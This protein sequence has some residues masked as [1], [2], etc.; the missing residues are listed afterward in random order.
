[1]ALLDVSKMITIFQ[2]LCQF[3][4]EFTE[5]YREDMVE[6]LSRVFRSDLPEGQEGPDVL[7]L[8]NSL[9][10]RLRLTLEKLTQSET[11]LL[12]AFRED[13]EFREIRRQLTLELREVFNRSRG[14]CRNH[15]GRKKSDSA[16]FPARIADDPGA[17]LRQ[18]KLVDWR[19]GKPE[20]ELGESLIPGAVT[21]KESILQ[22]HQPK[23]EE[24]RSGLADAV[25]RKARIE[26]KQVAKDQEMAD[27]RTTYSLFVNM[28]QSSFRLA[29]QNE[30]AKRLIRRRRR[31][32]KSDSDTSDNEATATSK[33]PTDPATEP[34]EDSAPSD[35]AASASDSVSDSDG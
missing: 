33:T 28:V 2:R 6:A 34:S 4:E 30:M 7:G 24:L 3:A 19:L 14:E 11:E 26:G 22:I 32:P 15:F 9:L 31:S 25:R 35:D 23:A 13:T 17:L 10:Q 8:I 12:E 21:T 16:G 18:T 27:F 29:G 5:E 1:M 20:F